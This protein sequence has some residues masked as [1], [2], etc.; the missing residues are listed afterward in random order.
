MQHGRPLPYRQHHTSD[1]NPNQMHPDHIVT[2]LFK[3]RFNIILFI[4]INPQMITYI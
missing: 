4:V 3:I 1:S 2:T